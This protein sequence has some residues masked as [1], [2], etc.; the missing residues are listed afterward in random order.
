M[1]DRLDLTWRS[2]GPVSSRYMRETRPVNIL[3]GPIGAGKTRTNFSKAIRLAAL[4]V[5]SRQDGLRKFKLCVVHA[6]YRQLWRSTLPSWFKLIPK[7]QGEWTGAENAPAKH[8]IRFA[9]PDGSE[10][11]FQVDFIA[12]GENAA[13]D[14]MRGYEPT[15]FFLNEL[16]LLSEEVYTFARGRTGRYPDMS[17]GGPT[18]HGILADCNAPERSSWL[19]E[20]IFQKVKDLPDV[21]LLIQPSGLSDAAENLENLPPNYY[22]GQMS[23]QPAWYVARMIKNI[24][25]FS[26]EGKPVFMEFND[27]L[28]F[29]GCALAP[30]P[31]L[32]LRI[33][34]D[35]GGS[36]A[37]VIGQK[38][39]NG[40][41]LILDEL[42]CEQ[43]TGA[44]R[45]GRDL[46]RL[47]ADRYPGWRIVKG[48]AD[49]ASQ[50]G[51]DD[52]M[53]EKSW[54]EIFATEA[55]MTVV[56]APTNSLLPRLE[57]VRLPLTRLIDGKPELLLSSRCPVLHEGFN[58]G[59]Q[60]RKMQVPGATRYTEEPD[61]N[62]FSHPMDALQ[63][64]LSA[65]GEDLEIRGRKEQDLN[66]LRHVRHQ[67]DWDPFT[68]Q[69]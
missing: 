10:V 62:K 24:P 61:K 1:N 3:N 68:L 19:Y 65:G 2:P 52:K 42:V 50:Y 58:S 11:L 33:G 37:C 55:G 39:D 41:W 59:Y 26:R 5:P 54:M 53:G 9:L 13:E 44:M 14:V 35:G 12:I 45:A 6:N 32:P 51:A 29:A 38:L 34:I 56:P 22:T 64:L 17:E 7:D 49:P 25:G 4:Q 30:V 48:W 23:G 60:Y 16:D 18:W 63:Y 20:N 43:G 28:H 15:A 40:Q 69:N 67:T 8:V 36:P 66:R 27:D 57:A 21:N 46:A 47:L 31:G